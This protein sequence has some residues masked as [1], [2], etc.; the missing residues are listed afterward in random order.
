M[1]AGAALYI[2]ERAD[3]IADGIQLAA[4]TIDSGKASALL[5]KLIAVSNE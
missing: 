2:G 4:E 1:N 5:D 3:S